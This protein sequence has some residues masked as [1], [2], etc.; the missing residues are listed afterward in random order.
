MRVGESM[1]VGERGEGGLGGDLWP[2]NDVFDFIEGEA[3]CFYGVDCRQHV[4]YLR[5]VYVRI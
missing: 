2:E 1:H 5:H 3:F 4:A